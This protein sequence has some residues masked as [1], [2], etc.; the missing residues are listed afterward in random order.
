MPVEIRELVL[1]ASIPEPKEGSSAGSGVVQRTE[2]ERP[3]RPKL[4]QMTPESTEKIIA[5]CVARVMELL[6]EKSFR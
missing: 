3:Q 2:H 6:N 1:R 5:L 4:P